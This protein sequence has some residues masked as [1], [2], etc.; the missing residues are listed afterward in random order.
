MDLETAVM[1]KKESFNETDKAIVSYLL[2]YPEAASQ[3]SLLELA[4]KL[5][6]SKSAIFRLSKKFGIKWFQRIEIWIV[7]VSYTKGAKR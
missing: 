6:V 2:K 1:K 4:Q 7:R 5:Y 3:L